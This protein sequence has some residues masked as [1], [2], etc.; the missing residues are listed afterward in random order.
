MTPPD[1]PAGPY[2]ADPTPS[3]ERRAELIAEF[4][5]FPAKLRQLVAGLTPAQ[6]DAPYKNWT[7]RQIVHHLADS[8]LNGYV[9]TKLTLT[10]DTPVVKPY[11]ESAWS[12]LPDAT[13]LDVGVSLRLLEAVHA[14][15]AAVWR[16]M[17]EA[18][19][20]RA[21]AHPEYGRTFGLGEVLGLYAWHGRHHG[22]MVDW[23][24][25]HR[26]A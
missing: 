20:A 3:A 2:S 18:D 1:T 15:W 4:E 10:E 24:K 14:R 17:G 13:S 22:A 7:V 19:F 21:Y 25:R 26:P 16:G 9:R 23:V 11:D 8:H 6:I 5:Q 12:R